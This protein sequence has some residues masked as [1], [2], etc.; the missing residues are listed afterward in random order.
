MFILMTLIEVLIYVLLMAL[1]YHEEPEEDESKCRPSITY[2]KENRQ[3]LLDGR[4][5]VTT[6]R[7]CSLNRTLFEYLYSNPGRKITFEELDREI[8]K[9]R[10]INLAKMGDAMGFKC[11]L[12]RLLF[13]CE[14][15]TITYHPDKLSR[16]NGPL[17]IT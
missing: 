6:F 13:T 17:K 3:V 9:G 2:D 5:I 10:S 7:N 11:E 1:L 15:D 4:F 16:C 14:A 8:F 12:R